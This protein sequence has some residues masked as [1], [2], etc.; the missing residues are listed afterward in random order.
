M[1]GRCCNT[2][3]YCVFDREDW[4]RGQCMGKWAAHYRLNGR[5]HHLGYFDDEVEA[6]RAY[7]YA[8]VG[9]FGEFACVNFPREWPAERRGK[10]RE[11]YLE[12]EVA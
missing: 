3:V 7:D 10:V 2:C 1:S 11:E 5:L 9:A 4:L 6:A 12:G 8:A